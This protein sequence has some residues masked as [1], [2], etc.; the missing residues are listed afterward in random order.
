MKMFTEKDF[1]PQIQEL[2]KKRGWTWPPTEEM[3][4]EWDEAIKRS[5]GM[6]HLDRENSR[7]IW[8]EMRGHYWGDEVE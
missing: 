5:A 1:P 3:K 2:L 7:Q 8:L 6:L 4:K